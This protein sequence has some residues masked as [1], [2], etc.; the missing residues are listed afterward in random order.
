VCFHTGTRLSKGASRL[1]F[2]FQIVNNLGN[3]SAF[4]GSRYSVKPQNRG[5]S[6]R[7]PGFELIFVQKPFSR[8]GMQII[9]Y[10][11]VM[12]PVLDRRDPIMQAVGFLVYYRS[13]TVIVIPNVH[14]T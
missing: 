4:P 10:E 13:S 9:E 7:L 1:I 8:A 6:G 5:L 2:R 14:L 3:K 11:L 12:L